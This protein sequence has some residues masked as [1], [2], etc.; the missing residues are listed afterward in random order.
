MS[1]H[2]PAQVVY[3]VLFS[4]ELLTQFPKFFGHA[5]FFLFSDASADTKTGEGWYVPGLY[6]PAQDR[7]QQ[8]SATAVGSG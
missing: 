7:R 6:K 5:L 8:H 4:P 3:H 2:W 1:T